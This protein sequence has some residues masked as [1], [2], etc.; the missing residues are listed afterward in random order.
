MGALYQNKTGSYNSALGAQAGPDSTT[1][2]L[3]NA[4]AIGYRADVAQSNA[5]VLG[6]VSN[7]N[8]CTSANRCASVNVGVG[9][10]KPAYPLDVAGTIRSS[11][12]GFMFPDGTIQTTSASGGGGGGGGTITGVTA[13]AGLIGGGTTGNVTLS[14]AN[15][16]PFATLG[17]NSFTGNQSVSGNLTVNGAVTGS[18]FQIG[19]FLFAF[20]SYASANA[21]LGFAG[22][23]TTTGSVNIA[24]GEN[25]LLNNTTGSNNTAVGYALF[26]NTTGSNNAG[27]GVNTLINNTTGAFNSALGSFAGQVLDG[28]PG[29]GLNDTGLGA[30]TA[31]ATGSLSNATAVGSNAEVTES[32]AIVLGAIT[33]VNGGTSVNVG[34]GTTA[35]EYPLDVHGS[36]QLRR[37]IDPSCHRELLHIG[38][39]F[40]S[41]RLDGIGVQ[42]HDSHQ[43]DFSLAD[44]E[45][46]RGDSVGQPE[47]AIRRFWLDTAT[48]RTVRGAQRSCHFCCHADIQRHAR[49]SG[50]AGTSGTG[51]ARWTNRSGGS[52]WRN[53]SGR[54][55]GTTR[56]SRWRFLGSDEGG[57]SA[58]V[59]ADVFGWTRSDRRGI[60][61]I[62]YLDSEL[63]CRNRH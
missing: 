6:A 8:G 54:T 35:P 18:S 5:L 55:T 11:S 56:T 1:P 49:A 44:A 33:G 15:P 30:G 28:T 37:R 39:A 24:I 16:G 31:F 20:G 7:V 41:T 19:S 34:I 60:R 45:C 12:G 32:N 21:F 46:G 62:E 26:G 50:A 59:S 36:R 57:A 10:T 9:T 38:F 23:A 22:N 43:S 17:T 4:T 29:T 14:L 48:D 42:R 53:R 47:S 13:G 61:R 3:T 2:A 52:N 40:Q 25:S 63:L 51:G 27:V 58:M